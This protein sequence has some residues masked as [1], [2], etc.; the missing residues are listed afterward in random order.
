MCVFSECVMCVFFVGCVW[1]H[2]LHTLTLMN[3]CVWMA[4][5]VWSCLCDWM[6][7]VEYIL[8]GHVYVTDWSWTYPVWSCL[9]DCLNVPYCVL[10]IWMYPGWI[11]QCILILYLEDRARLWKSRW[12]F[13]APKNV[14]LSLVSACLPHPD[15]GSNVI[16]LLNYFHTFQRKYL[17]IFFLWKQAVEYRNVFGDTLLE[18]ICF[19]KKNI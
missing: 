5:P 18:I 14:L 8:F 6:T 19:H 7:E 4:R 11:F 12:C 17:D 2:T 10:I 3:G 13:R 15:L 9:C 16:I 1:M